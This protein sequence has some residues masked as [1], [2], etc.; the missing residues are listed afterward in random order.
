MEFMSLPFNLR[1]VLKY[2]SKSI[3][4][5]YSTVT[6]MHAIPYIKRFSILLCS[7]FLIACPSDDGECDFTNRNEESVDELLR[8]TP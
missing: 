4:E 3:F 1:N 8:I 6:D 2:Y 7:L 5:L